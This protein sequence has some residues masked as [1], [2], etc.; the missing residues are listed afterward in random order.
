MPPSAIL[1]YMWNILNK[2]KKISTED[3]EMYFD[4]IDHSA[5]P[6]F[7]IDKNHVIIIWNKSCERLTG[8]KA[9][10]MVGTKK[11]WAPFYGEKRV[12][13]ADL[14]LDDRSGEAET[15]YKNFSKQASSGDGLYAEGWY[16]N[17]GGSA[18]Y[19]FF[20]ASPIKN[21]NG[22]IVGAV[23]TLEDI[24]ERRLCEEENIK[25]LSQTVAELGGINDLIVD[26]EQKIRE[27]R[28]EIDALKEG[29]K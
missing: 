4:I 17:L 15:F 2:S 12:V 28:S 20:N 29:T 18:R 3:T 8:T 5:T 21:I 22:E 13:L 24:T 1:A 16:P 11:Q 23:E 9:K 19:I 14:V 7:A 27:M 6:L 26:K 25:H 10:D